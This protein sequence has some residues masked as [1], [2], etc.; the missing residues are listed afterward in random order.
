MKL[1]LCAGL[2]MSGAFRGSAQSTT[3]EVA[4]IR[5]GKPPSGGVG[6]I[7]GLIGCTGGPGTGDPV[8]L[9]C[10]QRL[11]SLIATAYQLN[12]YQF[13]PPDWMQSSWFEITA[14][15][16][17]GSTQQQVRLMERNLL[18]ER[19]K[20]AVHFV[21]KEMQTYEMTVGK[22]GPKFKEWDDIL[23]RT[24]G[25]APGSGT[26][27]RAADLRLPAKASSVE[28]QD[29]NGRHSGRAK[30]SMDALAGQL[31]GRLGR[32]VID[33]TGL[34]G[35]YDIMLDFVQEP[36]P[37]PAFIPPDDGP[38][39]EPP[40]LAAGPTLLSAVQ[41]QLGLKL[42]PKKGTIDVLIVD[43]VEKVPTDN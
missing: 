12:P 28:Y 9:K 10:N 38:A 19:F 36:A 37:R 25:D 2:L 43:H 35:E 13:T 15:I 21:K 40:V 4:A 18:A 27:K 26:P 8:R 7:T 20:L 39:P 31:S 22:D 30:E 33:V 3:F 23:A 11:G 24:D 42:E 34:T 29:K 16:P 17:A 1:V 5:P 32:P 6:P 14:N 41:S